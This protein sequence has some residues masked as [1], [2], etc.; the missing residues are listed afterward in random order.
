MDMGTT[1][2]GWT[3]LAEQP[4][5]LLR[6]Y[7]FGTGYANTL[8][9]RLPSGDWLLISPPLHVPGSELEALQAHGRVVAFLAINGAHYMGIPQCLGAFPDAR[10]YATAAAS[11]RIAKK[12]KHAVQPL[13]LESLTPLLGDAIRIVPADG[14]KIGDVLVRIETDKGGVLYAGDF[15][16]NIQRLP[17]NPIFRLMFK[18]TDS[19]PGLKV[20]H[21]FFKFFTSSPTQLRDFLIREIGAFPPSILVPGHGDVVA[22]PELGPKLVSMLRAAVT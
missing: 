22:Q 17:R 2:E 4:L 15:I 1:V 6:E 8:A 20:F 10:T 18:L 19:G 13:P 12:T 5:V 3:T 7:S 9:V 11:S 21:L 14:C 16:A